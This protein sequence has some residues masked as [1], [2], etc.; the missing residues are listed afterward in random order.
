MIVD[1]NLLLYAT[2]ADDVRWRQASTWLTNVLNGPARVALPWHC[3]HAFLRL[4]TNARVYPKPLTTDQAWDQVQQ[5]LAAPASW[6][7]TQGPGY[8]D[9]LGDLL[10]R[11]RVTGPLVPDATLA[12][13]AV[14]HGIGVW[15]TDSDFA[16]FPEIRWV[17]PLRS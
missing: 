16:R 3:L 4:S 7:P 1:A 10:R 13:L 11:H 14:E 12:A 8:A 5:W 9:V 2:N 17:D 15:S 6:V